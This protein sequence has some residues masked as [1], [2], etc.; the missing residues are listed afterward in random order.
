MKTLKRIAAASVAAALSAGTALANPYEKYDGT[1]IVVSWPALSHYQKAEELVEEFTEETGIDVEID[2]LQYLKL[3]DAQLLEMSKDEGEFDVVV[4]VVMWKGE[5]VSKGLLT[6]LSQFFTNGSLVDPSYDIDDIADAYLQNGGIVG[7]RKGYLPGKSGA[8]YGIPFG[9]ETSILAYRK[10]ILEEQGIEPP[11]T[12]DELMA[13]LPKLRE[14]GIGAMTS[15]GSTG[16]QVTAAWL[17]H[18]APLGGTVFDDEWNPQINSPEAVEA[19]EVLRE[20]TKTGPNGIPSYGFSEASAAFLQGDAAMYLDTLKIA[21]MSRDPK[22]S[23]ID[24]Q[25]GYALHP[26]GSRCGSE[27]G[28]FAMGVPA[29]SQN[30]EAAFLFIQYM[31]SKHGDQRMVELGGDPVRMS[32]LTNPENMAKYPEFEVVA[33]QLPCADPD[34]R[35]LIPEWNELNLDVLGQALTKVITT[36]DPIQPIM[37]EANEQ[38]RAIMERAGYYTWQDQA[39]K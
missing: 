36:D 28:G 38:A 12:Y 32:T 17:L 7:G 37:D 19:A 10:D 2:A 6:P 14:A 24:G 5:Y 29:N 8:L 18:L 34:W 16:H 33:E 15:R 30:Q 9:A 39:A 25:V 23:K 20:I 22:L 11:A 13:A 1:T 21:S 3:R 35:P 27:T 26:E 4:W 31:T